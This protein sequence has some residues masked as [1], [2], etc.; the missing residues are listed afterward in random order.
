VP[1]PEYSKKFISRQQEFNTVSINIHSPSVYINHPMFHSCFRTCKQTCSVC[2]CK[3]FE[4]QAN[5][6]L[7]KF[8]ILNIRIQ[9]VLNAWSLL[10]SRV[11]VWSQV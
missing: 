10:T 8:R 5:I 6:R 4:A 11:V 9:Y 3:S 2:L 1:E 7:G